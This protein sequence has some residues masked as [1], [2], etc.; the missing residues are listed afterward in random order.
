MSGSVPGTSAPARV[1]LSVDNTNASSGPSHVAKA[2]RYVVSDD[3]AS[4][5]VVSSPSSSFASATPAG[6]GGR[7]TSAIRTSTFVARTCDHF[8]CQSQSSRAK[9]SRVAA[10]SDVVLVSPSSQHSTT[11]STSLTPGLA[12]RRATEPRAYTPAT[13]PTPMRSSESSSREP[14]ND[15]SETSQPS[16][17]AVATRAASRAASIHRSACRAAPPLPPNRKA[18]LSLFRAKAS[19][20]SSGTT[21]PVSRST[22][23]LFRLVARTTPARSNCKSACTPAEGPPARTRQ[24]ANRRAALF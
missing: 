7:G 19:A 6:C 14:S 4:A 15:K 11:R 21:A 9:A 1:T 3:E 5:S 17:A 16:H 2:A 20:V 24:R 23:R 10:R 8:V 22:R 18:S 12:S 13:R